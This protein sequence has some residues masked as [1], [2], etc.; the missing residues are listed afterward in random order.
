MVQDNGEKVMLN[1]F[2]HLS[3]YRL[4]CSY[5]S[6]RLPIKQFDFL[7]FIRY[8]NFMMLVRMSVDYKNIKI[9]FGKNNKVVIGVPC[10]LR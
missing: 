7:I 5:L 1:L 4:I 3:Y 9:V 8:S 6:T 2:Q 10:K